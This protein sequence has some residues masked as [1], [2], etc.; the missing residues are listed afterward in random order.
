MNLLKKRILISIGIFLALVVFPIEKSFA[1]TSS[2]IKVNDDIEVTITRVLGDVNET[3]TIETSDSLD[4]FSLEFDE[5]NRITLEKKELEGLTSWDVKLT[6][7]EKKYSGNINQSLSEIKIDNERIATVQSLSKNSVSFEISKDL[8]GNIFNKMLANHDPF[9]LIAS[10]GDRNIEVKRENIEGEDK[11]TFSSNEALESVEVRDGTD[12]IIIKYNNGNY[13]VSGQYK[14]ISKNTIV[15]SAGAEINYN[16]IKVGVLIEDGRN[17]ITLSSDHE[18][19]KRVAQMILDDKRNITEITISSGETYEIPSNSNLS[20]INASGKGG[21]VK[22]TVDS[23]SSSFINKEITVKYDNNKVVFPEGT[24]ITGPGGWSG[25][26]SLPEIKDSPTV[27]PSI[28]G[29][30][31]NVS[32]TITIGVEDG[33]LTFDKPVQLIFNGQKGKR[34]GFIKGGLFTEIEACGGANNIPLDKQDCK[35]DLESDLIVLTTHF[36]EFVVFTATPISGG[37]G[38]GPIYTFSNVRADVQSNQ[39][40]ITFDVSP[41]SSAFLKYGTEQGGPYAELIEADEY[42]SS[43]S[44]TLTGLSSG[45]YYYRVGASNESSPEYSFIYTVTEIQPGG[46]TIPTP[47]VPEEEIQV[48]K[49]DLNGDGVVDEYDF[50]LLMANWGKTGPNISDLNGDGVVDE[51]DFS[52]L[53]ANWTI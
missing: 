19:I 26:M 41:S 42:K 9:T 35:Y 2:F 32:Q 43:H 37:G 3:Y 12:N 50:S 34:V 10:S 7:K 23:E 4:N 46:S 18:T 14:G 47:V 1:S 31:V 25:E 20:T 8:S 5:N 17:K 44:F 21:K 52:L 33:D 27:T 16:D 13:E 6:Y 15:S 53:M 28:S 38:G 49:G 24:K 29:H 48:I 36:T 45:T 22:F 39:V 11:Y 40:V 30:S 51:Y